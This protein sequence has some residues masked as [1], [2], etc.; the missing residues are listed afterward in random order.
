MV[1]GSTVPVAYTASTA[2]PISGDVVSNGGGERFGQNEKSANDKEQ[3]DKTNGKKTAR[4][5]LQNLVRGR[6]EGKAGFFIFCGFLREKSS[7]LLFGGGLGTRLSNL[8]T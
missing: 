8:P 5:H 3:D 4:H 6:R 1:V 7:F 2:G